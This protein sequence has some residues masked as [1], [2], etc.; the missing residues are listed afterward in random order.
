M[1]AAVYDKNT[2]NMA[3]LISKTKEKV[4]LKI[5]LL[6]IDPSESLA[7]LFSLNCKHQCPRQTTASR[8][9]HP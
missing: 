6:F 3:I 2:L 9:T 7:F 8:H 1:A 4:L 5:R